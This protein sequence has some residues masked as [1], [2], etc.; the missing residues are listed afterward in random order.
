MSVMPMTPLSGVRISWLMLARNS[1]LAR[2]AAS[3]ACS[4]SWRSTISASQIPGFGHRQVCET[5]ALHNSSQ[6]SA[7]LRH[8]LKEES[9]PGLA[10]HRQRIPERLQR[11]CRPQ[12]ERRSPLVYLQVRATSA[13][14]KLASWERSR[15][16]AGFPEESTRSRQPDAR[17]ELRSFRCYLECSSTF[18]L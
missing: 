7:D 9:H 11:H 6:H 12:R 1:L 16:R 10:P 4:A 15:M 8:Q 3:A 2:L 17:I 13:L 5:T 18:G 14:E